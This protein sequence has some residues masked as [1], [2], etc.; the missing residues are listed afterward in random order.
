MYLAVIMFIHRTF[1]AT[2]FSI[3]YCVSL[4]MLLYIDIRQGKIGGLGLWNEV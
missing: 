1:S 4:I 3:K 2:D